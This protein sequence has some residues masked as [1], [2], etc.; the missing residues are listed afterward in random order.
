MGK[1]NEA[2][3][4]HPRSWFHL[5]HGA[6]PTHREKL[7]QE[8]ETTHYQL[9][10]VY[11]LD[12]IVPS[13]ACPRAGGGSRSR[14]DTNILWSTSRAPGGG[15]MKADS[16]PAPPQIHTTPGQTKGL[17]QNY[18]WPGLEGTLKSPG[19]KPLPG[20]TAGGSGYF[21]PTEFLPLLCHFQGPGEGIPGWNQPTSL[22]I[23]AQLEPKAGQHPGNFWAAQVGGCRGSLDP[24]WEHRLGVNSS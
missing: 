17:S 23:T 16:C 3:A 7:T 8:G 18:G 22:N 21:C 19:S 9:H 2:V 4:Q 11:S 14:Q 10:S 20:G 12:K 13:W 1:R 6:C 24:V 15:W 5:Q